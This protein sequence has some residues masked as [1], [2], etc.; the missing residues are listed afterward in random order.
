MQ[1]VVPRADEEPADGSRSQSQI[2]NISNCRIGHRYVI[3]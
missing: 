2:R 3:V 1:Q